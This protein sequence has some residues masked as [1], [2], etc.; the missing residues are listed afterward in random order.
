MGNPS[1]ISLQLNAAV[2]NGVCLAQAVAGAGNLTINGSLATG[3]VATFD[4]PRRVLVAS[5]GNN[6]A[7]VFTI[8]GT[9]RDGIVQAENITGLTAGTDAYT[10]LD[11]ADVTVVYASAAC[12]GNITVGT[13]GIGSSAWIMD[14]FM[15]AFWALSVG[16]V[17]DTGTAT[18]SVEYT[19]D[20]PNKTGTS[21]EAEPQQFSLLPTSYVPPTAWPHP[22]LRGLTATSD[23]NFANQPVMAHRVT[24]TAGTGQVTM[25]S[26][27]AGI[28]S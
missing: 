19:Y 10:E 24:V 17:I 1:S 9:S 23:G 22:T 6:A 26:M 5:S 28:I 21:Q 16:V 12:L 3:G 15:A 18:Y 14:N 13:N 27:Q 20:D 11:Y 4:S 7:V 2:A 25:Q 8:V